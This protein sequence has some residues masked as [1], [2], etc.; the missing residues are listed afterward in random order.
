MKGLRTLSNVVK[1]LNKKRYVCLIG[2]LS[3]CSI[4]FPVGVPL[5][6]GGSNGEQAT[7]LQG[8]FKFAYPPVSKPQ[9]A[10]MRQGF[11]ADKALEGVTA[12]LNS[13]IKL[14]T[15][16]TITFTECGVVNAFYE[17]RTRRI[18]MCYELYEHLI[19]LFLPHTKSEEELAKAV[20]G[21]LNF[22]LIH[23]LGHALTDVLNLPITGKEEDAVDQLATFILSAGDDQNEGT[24]LQGALYFSLEARQRGPIAGQSAF[25]DEHSFNEQR[26]FN[27][28]CWVYGHNREAYQALVDVGFLPIERAQ[29][30]PGE[31]AKIA[32]SWSSLLAPYTKNN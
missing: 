32:K 11:M 19:V 7:Q 14:P 20:E 25:A 6:I 23:E 27:I 10:V 26:Y 5:A 13:L 1:Q 18:K 2:L 31:Y 24:A 29:R 4:G 12:G 30:C 8:I 17:P 28:V 16:L 3:I 22:V 15:D 21:A 9:Y